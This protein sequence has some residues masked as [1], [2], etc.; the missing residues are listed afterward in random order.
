M[1]TIRYEIRQR[2]LICQH[3]SNYSEILRTS[4]YTR[5]ISTSGAQLSSRLS[6]NRARRTPPRNSRALAFTLRWILDPEKFREAFNSRENDVARKRDDVAAPR[7]NSSTNDIEQK[8]ELLWNSITAAMQ[9]ISRPRA[10]VDRAC[11]R[12]DYM[13]DNS[14]SSRAIAIGNLTECRQKG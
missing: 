5:K 6:D 9:S 3:A 7:R 13:I 10:R 2:D 11:S 8:A 14:R 4:R 1:Q 12:E